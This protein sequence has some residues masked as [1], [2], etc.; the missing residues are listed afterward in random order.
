MEETLQTIGE[1]LSRLDGKVGALDQKVGAL[2]QKVGALDKKVETGFVQVNTRI[3]GLS[4]RFDVMKGN[5]QLVLERFDD[6]V[7]KDENN[8]GA[9]KK[10][11]ER[12]MAHDNRL[13]ALETGHARHV[14]ESA[15]PPPRSGPA[16]TNSD[17]DLK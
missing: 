8:L 10:F 7:K 5:L 17:P 2:D 16:L 3:D 12:F 11:E 9:H 13:L 6:F 4:I 1:K 15:E 14:S